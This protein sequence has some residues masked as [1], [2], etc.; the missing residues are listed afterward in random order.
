M[1]FTINK[2]WVLHQITPKINSSSR[3]TVTDRLAFCYELLAHIRH[4]QFLVKSYMSYDWCEGSR[5][6]AVTLLFEIL[7]GARCK[8]P[9]IIEI[10]IWLNLDMAHN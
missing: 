8:G 4:I 2:P 6:T 7:A 10:A 9:R 1:I 3:C 5:L